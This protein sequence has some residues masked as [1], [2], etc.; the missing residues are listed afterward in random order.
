ML[1]KPQCMDRQIREAFWLSSL[2]QGSSLN[3]VCIQRVKKK[4]GSV[5]EKEGPKKRAEF[6]SRK[7]WVANKLESRK[8]VL[9]IGKQSFR[10]LLVLGMESLV[11]S[12]T[13]CAVSRIVVWSSGR[14]MARA[15][16][17]RRESSTSLVMWCGTCPGPLLATY[18]L[19]QGGTIR[20][21]HVCF[22]MCG[23]GGGAEGGGGGG[24][25]CGRCMSVCGV[26]V[27]VFVCVWDGN[28]NEKSMEGL[29]W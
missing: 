25:V 26:C 5:T 23:G 4:H 28:A 2:L 17:G 12:S 14:M 29:R 9:L 11:C 13:L 8:T 18:W 27:C 24:A 16:S 1:P 22:C 15:T 6:C 10:M 7:P 19:S 20:C 21:V 3:V